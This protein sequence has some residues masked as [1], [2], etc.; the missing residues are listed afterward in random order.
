MTTQQVKPVRDMGGSGVAQ[1][2]TCLQDFLAA[3][4]LG[5]PDSWG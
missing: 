3:G 2:T 5:F 4:G 1:H